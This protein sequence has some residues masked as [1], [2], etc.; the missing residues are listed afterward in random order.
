VTA[1]PVIDLQRSPAVVAAELDAVCCDVGFFQIVGHGVP[2]D[3]ADRAWAA[4]T[5]FFDL[6]LAE[7]MTVAKPDPTY[8]YGYVPMTGETLARSLGDGGAPDLKES[9]NAGPIDPLGRPFADDDEAGAFSPNLWPVVLPELRAATEPYF[10]EMLGL[11]ARLLGL[12]AQALGLPVDHF[13]S[14]IHESTSAIRALNYPDQG[15]PP[16]P[17][18]LRAGAHT[19]YGTL[20]ILRQDD[21]PGG[22][23]VRSPVDARWV[24]I[25]SVPG[26]FVVNVGDLLARWT[27]DRW[28]STLHRVVNPE[29]DERGSSRRQ[30]I[31]FFHN[32]NYHALVECL[33]TCL[34][35]GESPRYEPVLAGPHLMGKFRKTVT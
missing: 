20:T 8:P 23:E 32:A 10:R 24:P 33:P 9:F 34:A 16:A 12:F 21:A 22:L 18:Q 7:K 5:A 31:P 27:N 26:A 2:D 25:P 4:A 15:E 35:P 17:G 14:F 30:S 6:P 11:S 29:P 3:V 19:D 1:V 13:D 28:R